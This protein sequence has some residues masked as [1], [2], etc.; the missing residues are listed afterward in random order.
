MKPGV[1]EAETRIVKMTGGYSW[2]YS[3]ESGPSG[4]RQKVILTGCEEGLA[5]CLVRLREAKIEAHRV[6]QATAEELAQPRY[7]DRDK[8]HREEDDGLLY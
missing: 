8:M 6:I 7:H 1:P 4:A 3:F 2:S 5:R